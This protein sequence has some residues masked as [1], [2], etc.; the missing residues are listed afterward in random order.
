MSS[1][2][3]NKVL[4]AYQKTGYNLNIFSRNLSSM[5]N[6]IHQKISGRKRFYKEVDVNSII[7]KSSGK[8]LFQITLDGNLFL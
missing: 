1:V 6:T 4:R 3:L 2:I 5:S 8:S 7:E